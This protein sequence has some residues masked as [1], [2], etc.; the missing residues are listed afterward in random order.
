MND[1]SKIT[2]KLHSAIAGQWNDA[3]TENT[4]AS[5]HYVAGMIA[6][7]I[8]R[9]PCPELMTAH[10]A[11][12]QNAGMASQATGGKCSNLTQN[13]LKKTLQE[14]RGSADSLEV[15]AY[16]SLASM[17]GAY[18]DENAAYTQRRISDVLMMLERLQEL[19]TELKRVQQ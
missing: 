2:E 11:A 9:N 4:P 8:T 13:D 5:W 12:M 7:E 14:I 10:N 15:F 16:S 1:H 6:M 17:N 19:H 18:G 3:S